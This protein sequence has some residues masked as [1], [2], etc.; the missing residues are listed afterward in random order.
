[1]LDFSFATIQDL[2]AI[3]EIY[4]STVASRIVTA[5]LEPQTVESKKPWFYQHNNEKRPLWIVKNSAGEI[6]AWM[7][8]QSFY[9]RPA[10][11]ATVEI[12]IYIAPDQ[13]GKGYGKEILQFGIE[14]APSLGIEN[15]MGFI[16]SHNEPSLQLFYKFGFEK[17]GEFP[18]IATLDGQKRSLTILGKKIT[19]Q[20]SNI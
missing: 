8:F 9:G 12:S 15:L 14:Q 4:N 6:I 11:N 1:M 19:P 13:R 2:P 18:G 7:S 5:D 20:K 3:T 16:F 10:Y 17:W